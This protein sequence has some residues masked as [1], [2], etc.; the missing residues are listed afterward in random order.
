MRWA[1]KDFLF[2]VACEFDSRMSCVP[3]WK[4]PYVFECLLIRV[5]TAGVSNQIRHCDSYHY[6]AFS[7]FLLCQFTYGTRAYSP[8]RVFIPINTQYT[9]IFRLRSFVCSI[10]QWGFL[11]AFPVF[12]TIHKQANCVQVVRLKILLLPIF[13]VVY[14]IVVLVCQN[15]EGASN[16]GRETGSDP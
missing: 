1:M 5:S 4:W 7:G 15:G 9:T 16:K 10:D 6:V 8:Y 13:I 11:C 12:W 2:V 14:V 3:V